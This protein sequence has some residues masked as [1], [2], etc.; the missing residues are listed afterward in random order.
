MHQKKNN[1]HSLR[2]ISN[3]L[4][5]GTL[6]V[7]ISCTLL[8]GCSLPDKLAEKLPFLNKEEEST[9]PRYLVDE[10]YKRKDG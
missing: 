10:E 2:G 5:A 1:K 4:S 7:A 6:A 8:T 3:R 9:E